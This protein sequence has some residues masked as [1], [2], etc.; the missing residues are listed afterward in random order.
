[1][2]DSMRQKLQKRPRGVRGL[3]IFCIIFLL[4]NLLFFSTGIFMPKHY[5]D[6][7]IAPIGTELELG[8]YTLTITSWDWAEKDRAF[9]IIFEVKDLSLNREPG[10][11][12]RFRCGDSH[13]RYKIY[14]D[15][16]GLLVVRVSGVSSRF[17]QVAM[18][19]KAGSAS[20]SIY[21]DDRTMAHVERLEER[22]DAAY[23]IHAV[24]GKA[25]G[26]RLALQQL[27]QRLHQE[28]T[29]LPAAPDIRRQE[30]DILLAAQGTDAIIYDTDAYYNDGEELIGVIKRIWRT[31]HAA[32]ILLVPTDNPKN[33]IVKAALAVQIK[34]IINVALSPGEQ[35]DQLEKILTGYYAANGDREDIRA[36]EDEVAEDTR[37]LTSFVGQLYDAKQREEEREHT[38]IVRK[39]GTPQVLLEALG[40]VIRVLFGAVSIALMA[41]AML[42]LLYDNTR[43]LLLQNLQQLWQEICSMLGIG[44]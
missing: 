35:K 8:E 19:V 11:T 29:F 1:M 3:Q 42:A 6:V 30:N 4:G 9:E 10:Y 12:F 15:L 44:G 22:S 40:T 13:Y 25:A 16:G 18:T 7:E 17:A 43:E 37:T 32:P 41:I 5:K 39:K 21:M 27:E 20:R 24:E 34:N 26:H 2:L 31:N 38:V 23:R 36:A 28:V 14:R 33:E